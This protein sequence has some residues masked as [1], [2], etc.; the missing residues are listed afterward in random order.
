MANQTVQNKVIENV[1]G[2]NSK[3]NFILNNGF[4]IEGKIV[5]YDDFCILVSTKAPSNEKQIGDKQV[6]QNQLIYKH[7][8]STIELPNTFKY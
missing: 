7:N 8:I 4:R 3:V 6:F 1:K 5:A 2:K